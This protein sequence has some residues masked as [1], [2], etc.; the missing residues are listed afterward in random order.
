MDKKYDKVNGNVAFRESDHVYFNLKDEKKKYTSVTTMIHSYGQEFDKNFWSGIK[1]LQVLLEK[2][3]GRLRKNIFMNLIKYQLSNQVSYM[4]LQ[5]MIIIVNNKKFQ[6]FGNKRI[7]K[8]V[9]EGL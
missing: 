3:T 5:R 1:A 8:L 9:N 6:I 7:Q 4:I 2:T